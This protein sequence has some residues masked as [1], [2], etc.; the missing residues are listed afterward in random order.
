MD[1]FIEY[2]VK[3]KKTGTDLLKIIGVV[4]A[5]LLLTVAFWFFC[6]N[7]APRIIFALVCGCGGSMVR[8]ICNR[9]AAKHRV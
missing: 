4:A 8:C 5:A 2:M 6:N 3:K 1:T 7:Y 9:I